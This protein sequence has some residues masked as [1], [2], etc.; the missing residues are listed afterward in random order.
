M[1][2][3]LTI[4]EYKRF[5][6]RVH[7][8]EVPDMYIGSC[9]PPKE[10]ELERVFDLSTR[11]TTN[12]YHRIPPGMLRVI[13]EAL[14][15]AGDNVPRSM[16]DGYDVGKIEV[17]F[18]EK[19][20]TV[21]NGG[22]PIAL[23]YNEEEK[24]YDVEM[25]FSQYLTSSN[26]KGE[27]E[28]RDG[29]G[30]NGHGIKLTNT[31]SKWFTVKV[32]NG[33]KGILYT[34]S[35]RDNMSIIEKPTIEKY[36]KGDSFVEVSFEL[37]FKRFGYDGYTPECMA[38]FSRYAIEIATTW[39]V[40]L[41]INGTEFDYTSIKHL[42]E[43]YYGENVSSIIHY[44][45]PEGAVIQRKKGGE[46]TGYILVNGKKKK[47]LPTI[48]LA[49]IDSENGE[50]LSI[51]NGM[52]N[53]RGGVHTQA[54][55]KI[56]SDLILNIVNSDDSK[57]G[58]NI[59]QPKLTLVD[60]KKYLSM[61]LIYRCKNPKFD[62]QTKQEL[63]DPTPTVKMTLEELQP[64]KKWQ[65]V[66]RL[67]S[68]LEIKA[69]N[70]LIKGSTKKGERPDVSKLEDAN[71]AGVNGW[72]CVLAIME[73][74]SAKAMAVSALKHFDG[75]RNL[76]GLLAIRGKTLNVE[77]CDYLAASSNNEIQ[78]IRKA[79]GVLPDVDYS[80]DKNFKTLRYQGH[81]LI[82]TDQDH[83][84][85]HIKGLLINVFGNYYPSLI[86]RNYIKFLQTP[87][88]IAKKGSQVTDLYT[89][90]QID[91]FMNENNN[92]LS[93]KLRHIKGLGTLSK[94]DIDR[95]MIKPI[96]TTLI[97]SENMREYFR[98][99]FNKDKKYS[100]QRKEKLEK[101]TT[102][103][104]P[105]NPPVSI[106]VHD[107]F[108]NVFPE[109]GLLSLKRAI[110][111]FDGFKQSQRQAIDGSLKRREIFTEPVKV[112]NLANFISDKDHYE[113]GAISMGKT[114][115]GMAQDFVGSNNV[116]LFLQSGQFGTR[117]E[118]G[119]DAAN[120]RYPDVL[121]WDGIG[122]IIRKEDNECLT[123]RYVNGDKVEPEVF[124]PVI[125]LLLVNGNVGI[126]TGYSTYIPSFH[127][128]H[129]CL[130]LLQRLK[131]K[132]LPE[133][134][135]F[136]RGFKGQVIPKSR[137]I[138][139]EGE[140]RKCNYFVTKGTYTKF[141]DGSVEVTELPVGR[142][143]KTYFDWLLKL[144]STKMITSVMNNSNDTEVKFKIKGFPVP[145]VESLKLKKTY[146]LNNM[147]VIKPDGKIKIYTS[148]EEYMEDFY[149]WRL[150]CYEKRRDH[151][152]KKI[153]IS[154]D[155]LSTKLKIILAIKEKKVLLFKNDEFIDKDNL[156]EQIYNLGLDKEIVDSV[157]KNLQ[158]YNLT[159]GD[160]KNVEDQMKKE[161]D[162]L[163]KLH[164]QKAEEIWE[165]EIKEAMEVY[166]KRYDEKVPNVE[167]LIP[168]VQVKIRIEKDEDLEKEI[169]NELIDGEI[170]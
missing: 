138:N 53:P 2:A 110:P 153:K 95:I 48:E 17:T 29:S 41:V 114:I 111:C 126:A 132:K 137:E 83:D 100:N 150:E 80:E 34:Q 69:I 117:N 116:P 88:M 89:S 13:L 145:N 163:V 5:K 31:Y 156:L 55:Y 10:A 115:I 14:S 155:N 35:F 73:G 118:G 7:V 18:T 84:G 87:V 75:G 3:D 157:M 127:F 104:I 52:I 24:M 167:D 123:Y 1:S 28:E 60:V 159:K 168:K 50:H 169:E 16:K 91:K 68:E 146:S 54:C 4:G 135:P 162:L 65:L 36:P 30:R 143:T 45:W 74:E 23:N 151:Q 25:I 11:K 96:V 46:Q 6:T 20:C 61:I 19:V 107:F 42:L 51:C 9:I 58:K 71:Y 139:K 49:L 78:D 130:W 62:A 149:I 63:K 148:P 77:D 103:Q 92:G 12:I 102:S 72:K 144:E 131:N 32:G 136:F 158:I 67:L 90:G 119:K 93:W 97:E 170:E 122:K 125:P 86:K 21:R 15:N 98:I 38:L 160:A 112:E 129:L 79:L 165:E 56:S 76:I 66:R 134:I 124:W 94:A 39:Q 99:W 64:I 43:L 106:S 133:L 141:Q 70:K 26:Y 152:I 85:T 82:M 105:V 81:I 113:H 161:Y 121:L 101:W 120:P 109:F 154:I 59:G 147:T 37:D 128:L 8:L 40:P 57:K 142:W 164:N 44:E 27:D 47:V 166:C 33:D 140:K 108:E 22:R